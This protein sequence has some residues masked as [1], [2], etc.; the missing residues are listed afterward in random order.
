MSDLRA[1]Q[2]TVADFYDF[3]L[4]LAMDADNRADIKRLRPAGNATPVQ[5]FADGPVPDP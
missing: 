1:R 3:D 2:F 5:L 4:I